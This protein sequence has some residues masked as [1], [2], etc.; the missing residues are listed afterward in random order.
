MIAEIQKILFATDLSAG[1]RQ[2]FNYAATLAGRQGAGL[3]ILH[4]MEEQSSSSSAYLKS[5][6]GDQ[7]WQQI[8]ESQENAARQML[9]GKQ[10]EGALIR[11]TLGE[12]CEAAKAELGHPQLSTDDIIVTRG[13]VVDE[14]LAIARDRSCGLIVMGYHTRGKLGEAFLGSTTRRLLRRG[15][16]PVLL[17]RLPEAGD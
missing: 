7:R 3:V 8:K 6:L 13:N 15:Q 5:F 1:S 10:R 14:I 11:E 9:I 16:I 12:F 2:A 4:V 17:V